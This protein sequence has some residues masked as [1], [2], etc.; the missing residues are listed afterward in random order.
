MI[1]NRDENLI[2]PYADPTS[3]RAYALIF[4]GLTAALVEWMPEVRFADGLEML[5]LADLALAE[6]DT[7]PTYRG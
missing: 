2:N 7:H 1:E 4:N 6:Q 3:R 5:R